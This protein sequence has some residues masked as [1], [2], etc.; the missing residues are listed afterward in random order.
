MKKKDSQ[1]DLEWVNPKEIESS[2]ENPRRDDFYKDKDFLRLKESVAEHGVIVPAIVRRLS[3]EVN[4][5]KYVLIDGERRWKAAIETNRPEIPVYIWP[6]ERDIDVLATM[7][8][9]H[10]NQ[11]GWEAI[12]QA[13]ALERIVVALREKIRK[14][15]PRSKDMEKELVK[16]LMDKTGM[17][18]NNARSRVLFF[19]WP[20]KL[21]DYIYQAEDKNYYS[22]AVEIESKIVGPALRN[23][24]D[25][26]G[27]ISPDDIR[28]ALFA[29]VTGG[30]VDRAE[31]IRDAAILT[32][33]RRDT[34]QVSKAKSLLLEF[35][36][37]R[38]FTFPEAHE[39]YIAL[40]PEEAKKPAYS[41]RKLINT[42]MSLVKALSDYTETAIKTMKLKQKKDLQ[43]ALNELMGIARNVLKRLK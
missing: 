29:K 31:Q 36:K 41:S 28:R 37:D 38:S 34:K 14:Q 1:A 4:G 26:K 17:D 2:Q 16:Q 18:R 22:Y 35:I 9:I 39:Q 43:T 8:Q 12:E 42:I 3:R 21:R 13:R 23:F 7:F 40:F 15:H 32:K 24:P 20:K 10:M 19:R 6:R 11:E 33:R 30:F 5:K 25:L 27:R